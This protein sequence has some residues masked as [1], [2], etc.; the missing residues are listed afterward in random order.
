MPMSAP[1]SGTVKCEE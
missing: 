1:T